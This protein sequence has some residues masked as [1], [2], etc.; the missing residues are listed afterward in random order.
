MNTSY[1]LSVS[2]KREEI[3]ATFWDFVYDSNLFTEYHLVE[4]LKKFTCKKATTAER[5]VV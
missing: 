3:K 5:K 1:I 4:E 2:S